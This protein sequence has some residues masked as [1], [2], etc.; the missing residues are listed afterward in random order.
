VPK[1]SFLIVVVTAALGNLS[2]AVDGTVAT[3]N[4]LCCLPS[5]HFSLLYVA[6]FLRQIIVIWDFDCIFE[7]WNI[8]DRV[9]IY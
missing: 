6:V 7:W 4:A 9:R 2:D 3:S 8:L 1:R 5:S